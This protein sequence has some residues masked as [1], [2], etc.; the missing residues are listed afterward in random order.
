MI[1]GFAL[2]APTFSHA[3]SLLP[4][5]PWI[6]N[7]SESISLAVFGTIVVVRQVHHVAAFLIVAL[8]M[9]HIY[10]Q[11]WRDAFWNE[12][13]ISVVVSGYKYIEQDKP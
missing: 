3:N 11:I 2:M 1:T 8:A 7:V 10:L 4:V 5:W 9:I 6:L 13:H 12:G